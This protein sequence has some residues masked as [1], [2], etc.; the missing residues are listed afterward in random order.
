MIM[1]LDLIYYLSFASQY[2]KKILSDLLGKSVFGSSNIVHILL[3]NL[4][5]KMSLLEIFPPI[6][7]YKN[8]K[9]QI[10]DAIYSALPI[11]EDL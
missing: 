8:K 2:W 5:Y 4:L 9:S 3:W 1:S 10:C 7:G 11:F 6:F